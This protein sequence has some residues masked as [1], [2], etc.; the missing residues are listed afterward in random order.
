[1]LSSAIGSRVGLGGGGFGR[2]ART[3]VSG[4]APVCSSAFL[5]G[6]TVKESRRTALGGQAVGPSRVVDQPGARTLDDT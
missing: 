6:C 3:G 1:M 2:P 5:V 4:M